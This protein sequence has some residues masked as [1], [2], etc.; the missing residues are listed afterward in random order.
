MTGRVM[1]CRKATC[2]L[3]PVDSHLR[4]LSARPVGRI[5]A[6]TGYEG[7]QQ[8][9]LLFDHLVGTDQQR[10]RH[11]EADRLSGLEVDYQLELAGPLDGQLA[12]LG[13]P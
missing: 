5:R 13:P 8:T 9:K 3:S 1:N 11:V 2:A 6:T 4:T 12:C 7:P 10:R